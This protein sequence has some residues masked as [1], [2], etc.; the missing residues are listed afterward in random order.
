M[1]DGYHLASVMS[2]HLSLQMCFLIT[3][4]FSC[5]AK[6][7]TSFFKLIN[8]VLHHLKNEHL[9]HKTQLS[10]ELHLKTEKY[11]HRKFLCHLSSRQKAI[12][13][14]DHCYYFNQNFYTKSH[15]LLLIRT[16]H[17][18]FQMSLHFLWFFNHSDQAI[19]HQKET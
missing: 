16:Y 13:S 10:Y 7:F 12:I 8:F 18:H 6:C 5:R 4:V 15:P 14:M 3:Q 11:C 17:L 19:L 2:W 1:N 9:F